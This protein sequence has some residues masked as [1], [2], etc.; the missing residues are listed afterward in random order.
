MAGGGGTQDSTTTTGLDPALKPYVE[1]GLG[2]AK[3][4]YQSATPSFYPG[5][6]YVSPSE[7]T[8]SALQS[9][10]QRATA[11]SPLLRAAQ[12]EQLA[13]IQ[14]RGVN[15]FLE[16]ALAGV[17]R[18]AQEA[19]TQGVQGLQSRA[20]QSGRYGSQALNQQVGQAQDIFGRNLAE[21][22]G[23]LAYQSA[24][25]ER[26]RQQAAIAGAPQMA[27]ADYGDIQRLLTTGQMG[28][29]YQS[30]E[31]Q[32]AINRFNFEQNLPAMK[33]NQY[34]QFISGMPAGNITTQT[35]TPSGGK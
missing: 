16:G 3:S 20:A 28:E 8:T 18:Q 31:L 14:G 1:Y 11:G 35:A 19:Y 15:P 7:A 9:A 12:A 29:Q 30:A 2:E 24:E 23:Q 17:N 33:L 13:T 21:T 5:Q 27:E 32:D 4:L 34:G 26:A 25:A 22:G 6:T 10:Q